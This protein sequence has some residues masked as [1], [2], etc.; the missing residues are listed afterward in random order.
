M[1]QKN[2]KDDFQECYQVNLKSSLLGN[3]LTREGL[4]RSSNENKEEKGILRT[5]YGNKSYL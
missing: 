3:M 5:G 4:V 1:K 2:K